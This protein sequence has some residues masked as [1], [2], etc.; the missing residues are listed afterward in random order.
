MNEKYGG[1][2]QEGKKKGGIE[3][4]TKDNTQKCKTHIGEPSNVRPKPITN[5]TK[6]V[7][8]GDGQKKLGRRTP[9]LEEASPTN[10]TREALKP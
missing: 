7:V 6:Q 3:I 1:R 2:E 9:S 10:A 5:S 8:E 4:Q